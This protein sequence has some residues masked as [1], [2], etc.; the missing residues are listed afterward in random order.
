VKLKDAEKRLKQEPNNLG[1]RVQVAGMMREAGRSLEAVELYRSVALAYRDQ[2]RTQQA[3]AVCRSILEIAPED[4]ACQGLLAIL[5]QRGSSA[6]LPPAAQAPQPRSRPSSQTPLPRP[7]PVE[8]RSA[9]EGRRGE[10][11]DEP[12]VP[13]APAK[14]AAQPQAVMR[15]SPM[16]LAPEVPTLRPGTTLPPQAR[17]T[18]RPPTAPPPARPATTPTAPPAAPPSM[19]VRSRPVTPQVPMPARTGTTPPYKAITKAPQDQPIPRPEPIPPVAKPQPAQ[20]AQ[21]A[22]TSDP[23]RRSSFDE[24]PLPSPV[25]YHVADATTGQTKVSSTDVEDPTRPDQAHSGLVAAARKISGLISD[26]RGIPKELDLSAEL[27]TRQRRKIAS[28]ELDKIAAPPPTIPIE[29]IDDDDDMITPPPDPDDQVATHKQRA[30]TPSPRGSDESI[31]TETRK[32]A[33]PRIE[34]RTKTSSRPPVVTIPPKSVTIPPKTTNVASDRSSDEE[35][36][37]PRD[38]VLPDDDD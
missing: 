6:R 26:S 20:P 23:A 24:T 37:K 29:R 11:I 33:L 13:P 22:R 17:I 38:R 21:L 36:T 1:L 3:I 25:P 16:P 18:Q 32:S 10:V 7:A 9:A 5:Q 35:L 15:G 34:S 31:P 8:P 27:D 28:D 12:S 4:S 19:P 30:V 2:G 14:P